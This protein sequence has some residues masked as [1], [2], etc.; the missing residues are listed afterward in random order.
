MIAVQK[1]FPDERSC[2]EYLEA[3]RWPDGVRCLKCDH[4]RVSKF[5]VAGKRRVDKKTAEQKQGP[6]RFMYQCLKC[7]YQFQATTGTIF[8]D[9]HL[10]LRLW[11][12][13]TALICNAKK[14]LSAKQ[15]ERD[16]DVSYKTAW[17]LCHRLREAMRS[18]Q[19]LFDGHVE[20]DE[21]FIGGKYNP[22]S[23]RAK[24]DKQAVMGVVQRGTED[25]PSQVQAFPVPNR[26]REVIAEVIKE[27]VAPSAMIYTDEYAGYR[28]LDNVRGN[29]AIVI[30]SRGQYARKENGLNIHT[31]NAELFWGL[32]KRQ[33]I[34][35]HHW[36]SVKHLHRY[37][38][39][40]TYGFNNRAVDRFG[41]VIAGLL[42]GSALRYAALTAPETSADSAA[43]DGEN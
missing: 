1:Q 29:H 25:L 30:H 5:T 14:G 36:V 42:I 31:N 17:Y 41:M 37:L 3:S 12:M 6:D 7:K 18:E 20:M 15:V 33:L 35:Q 43:E 9:T 39:E 8:T 24:Y 4:D 26:S 19:S 10:P 34:G 16:L 38:D 21:T 13:A 27:R 32:F 23:R 40:R 2:H 28:H 22:R 11:F